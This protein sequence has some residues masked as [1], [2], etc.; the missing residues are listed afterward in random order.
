MWEQNFYLQALVSNVGCTGL[1]NLV[2]MQLE[3][4]QAAW[5]PSVSRFLCT[6]PQC[7]RPLADAPSITA[8][9]CREYPR[10]SS[11]QDSI[12]GLRLP[13]PRWRVGLE[14]WRLINPIDLILTVVT[15][16]KRRDEQTAD[17]LA[18]MT[19]AVTKP[20]ITDGIIGMKD[21]RLVVH[22]WMRWGPRDWGP[23]MAA[24]LAP[25]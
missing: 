19:R 7:K 8:I 3:L 17:G 23:G 18:S 14:S 25:P 10:A 13:L 24:P 15:E 11:L 4:S 20:W 21:E 5:P 16:K 12:S 9:Y 2:S 22:T 1:P 6:S